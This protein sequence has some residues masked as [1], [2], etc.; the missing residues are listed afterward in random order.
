MDK[1]KIRCLKK[2]DSCSGKTFNLCALDLHLT[3]EFGNTAGLIA[4][5]SI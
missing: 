1:L 5:E 4:D 3:L 2:R